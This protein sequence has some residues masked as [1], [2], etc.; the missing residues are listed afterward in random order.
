V[1]DP[2]FPIQ[3]LSPVPASS[4]ASRLPQK[5]QYH[6][7]PVGAA[8]AGDGPRSGLNIQ[9]STLFF[10]CSSPFERPRSVLDIPSFLTSFV[11][12]LPLLLPT[13]GIALDIGRST[14]LFRLTGILARFL[15]DIA[16]GTTFFGSFGGRPRCPVRHQKKNHGYPTQR[17]VRLHYLISRSPNAGC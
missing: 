7:P 6:Q 5:Y 8:L 9:M 17:P 11:L 4:P 15:P 14:I 12:R 10:G 3:T 2:Q 13:A 1:L 16:R